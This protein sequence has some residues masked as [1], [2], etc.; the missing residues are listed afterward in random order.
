MSRPL[1]MYGGES[2]RA[3]VY[4]STVARMRAGD[5]G[6]WDCGR[7]PVSGTL[8]KRLVS[9]V[10]YGGKKGCRAFR[11]LWQLGVRPRTLRVRVTLKV[12]GFEFV[13]GQWRKAI[14]A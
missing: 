7:S 12:N 6:Y 10:A 14:G 2:M 5:D 4:R 13:E 1:R 8:F 3:R 9:R 11:R